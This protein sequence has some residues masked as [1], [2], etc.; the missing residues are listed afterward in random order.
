MDKS[1]CLSRK[2]EANTSRKAEM[3]NEK[4]LI[5]HKME[6]IYIYIDTAI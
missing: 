3:Q 1:T 5:I 4:H 6:Y 2:I